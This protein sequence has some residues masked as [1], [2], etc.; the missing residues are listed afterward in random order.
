MK[1]KNI[2]SIAALLLMA[3][4]VKAQETIQLP[5]FEGEFV[6][7]RVAEGRFLSPAFIVVSDGVKPPEN[8]RLKQFTAQNSLENLDRT[9]KVFNEIRRQG[10]KLTGPPNNVTAEGTT[11]MSDYIFERETARD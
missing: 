7:V 2:L 11:L 10:Y 1:L 5:A 6:L 8:I 9:A 4:G 3:A